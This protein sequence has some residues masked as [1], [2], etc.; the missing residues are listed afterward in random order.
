MLGVPIDG[1]MYMF[2]YI[3][4]VYKNTYIPESQLQKKHHSIAYHMIRESITSGAT[5]ISK[6]DTDTNLAE[7]F[8]K[9][10]PRPRR[11]LLLNKFT[12]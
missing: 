8:T 4:A 6:E 9:V 5:Q 12:Y 3:E 7:L 1:S 11:E 2:Y 10:L